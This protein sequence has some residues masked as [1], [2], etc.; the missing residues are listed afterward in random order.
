MMSQS[1][2]KSKQKQKPHRKKESKQSKKKNID[3]SETTKTESKNEMA[4]L[5]SKALCKAKSKLTCVK[6][7]NCTY[8]FNSVTENQIQK[9]TK[10]N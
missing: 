10:H 6:N 2:Y 7:Y 4:A 9:A 5:Q 1:I 8:N 3:R